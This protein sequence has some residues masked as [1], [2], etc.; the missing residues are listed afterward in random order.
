MSK[1][2]T[3]TLFDGGRPQL[4]DAS[5]ADKLR[6]IFVEHTGQPGGGQLGI[7]RYLGADSGHD[8]RIVFLESGPVSQRLSD[9]SVHV[10]TLGEPTGRWFG[11][12]RT[13]R[14]IARLRH[15]SYDVVVANS[16]KAATA[17]VLAP[18]G[19]G[20]RVLYLRD[21]LNRERLSAV[22]WWFLARVVA[23]SFDAFLA[24][25]AWTAS[26]IPAA[27]GARPVRVAYPVSGT[28]C[29]GSLPA[30]P[31]ESLAILSL[32]RIAAWKGTH[33][34]IE[35]LRILEERGVRFTATI[36]GS[37]LFQSKKYEEQVRRM[38]AALRSDVSFVGQV[39]D[40]TT[41]LNTHNVLVSSNVTPEP[42]GQ[43]LIQGMSSGLAVVATNIGGPIEITEG[44]VS[45]LLVE[46]NSAESLADGLQ[47]LSEVKSVRTGFVELGRQRAAAFVD[48]VTVPALDDAIQ[49]LHASV[50]RGRG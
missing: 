28:R 4:P 16:M 17:M 32:S 20:V 31:S 49:E 12:L 2:S 38:A 8:R 11:L 25:S 18:R 43:V 6:V 42:F 26:T 1:S 40:V 3:R 44:G 47:Q 13:P 30:T 46:A 35:A 23:R 29:G 5:A 34:L 24:N 36:A 39:S 14:L 21:D 10:E 22:R 15:S 33:V 7:E 48:E 27:L 9:Q 50:M 19:N 37:A 45:G 41:L